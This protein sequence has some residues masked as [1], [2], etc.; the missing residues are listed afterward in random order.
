MQRWAFQASRNI[1]FS[2]AVSVRALICSGLP[3][4]VNPHFIG[5]TARFPALLL[6]ITGTTLVGRISPE[7]STAVVS[8]KRRTSGDRFIS[9]TIGRSSGDSSTKY[10]Q[11]ILFSLRVI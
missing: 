11:H 8:W 4:T 5:N 10:R 3:G 6:A 7:D 2:P 1:G 9:S